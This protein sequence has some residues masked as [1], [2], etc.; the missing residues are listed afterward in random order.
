MTILCIPKGDSSHRI[1]LVL[2]YPSHFHFFSVDFHRG[3]SSLAGVAII[4]TMMPVTKAVA[5]YMGGLQR[6]VMTAR[7]KRVQVNSEVLGAMKVVKLQA[8]EIPFMDRIMA[9]RDAE[10]R[11]LFNY[12]IAD[13]LSTML[14]SAVPLAIALGTFAAYVV[15]GHNLT[16]STALTSLALFDILRFPLFMLP[17]IIN[18]IVE[19]GVSLGR[20]RSFLLSEEHKSIEAGSLDDTGVRMT[21]VSA[22]YESL[23]NRIGEGN[24]TNPLASE[25]AEKSWELSLLKSQLEEAE[26]KIKELVAAQKKESS[27]VPT[28]FTGPDDH[29]PESVGK[30]STSMLCLKRV[31]FDCKPGTLVAVIGGVGCGKSSM[32]NAILGEVRELAGKTEVS[33]KLA[34]FSQSPF[35]LNATVKANI[36]FSH[37][38]EPVDEVKYRRALECCALMHDL[39]LLPAG[40]LTEIGEKGITLRCV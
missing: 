26:K 17:Q 39:E 37:V 19:A 6:Q 15:S 10:L 12:I 34:F 35:I 18:K 29:D 40:D 21:N 4:C 16:V 3:P 32:I 36:L 2:L 13:S 7:D 33:G 5:K 31:N 23:K 22:A 25:L 30:R 1:D 14:W 38:N 27:R 28:I 9:F 24:N 20:V 8:W 11:H